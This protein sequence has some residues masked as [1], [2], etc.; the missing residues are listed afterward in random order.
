MG[1]FP[2][3]HVTLKSGSGLLPKT[4]VEDIV[5]VSTFYLKTFVTLQISM[6]DGLQPLQVAEQR[7]MWMVR[8]HCVRD[9]RALAKV[10]RSVDASAL[11]D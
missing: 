2:S 6:T 7:F 4:F 8:T 1:W 5:K 11:K 10:A 9:P 3:N